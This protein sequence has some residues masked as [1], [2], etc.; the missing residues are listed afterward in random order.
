MRKIRLMRYFF[1]VTLVAFCAVAG[2][3]SDSGRE[4]AVDAALKDS[5]R[6]TTIEWLDSARDY[7][8]IPEGQKLDVSFRF[9]N[10]GTTPLV[11]GQVRVSCGCTVA[12]QP[13]APIAPGEEGWIKASFDS[14]GHP[15]TNHKSLFVTA[16]TKGEQAFTL[17][18]S[19]EV[20]KKAS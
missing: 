8:K 13:V 10:S 9:R 17:H 19:V 12:E 20:E 5:A 15:G 2:C 4:K 6:F 3:A 7:G 1:F 14:Q 11:I 16:N 18:F